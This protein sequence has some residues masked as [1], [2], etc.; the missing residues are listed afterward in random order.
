MLG[1]LACEPPAKITSP[2]PAASATVIENKAQ[3]I[4]STSTAMAPESVPAQ[5]LASASASAPAYPPC[6]PEVPEP[7]NEMAWV[8]G[9]RILLREKIYFDFE[10]SRLKPQSFP[11]LDAVGDILLRNPALRVEVE[12][13]LGDPQQHAYGR[14]LSQDRAESVRNYLVA[15]KGVPASQLSY[16]GYENAKPISDTRTEEGRQKNRRIELVILGWNGRIQ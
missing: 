9:C 4:A 6:P 3:P 2:T 13:H 5:P 1:T 7:A 11:V 14:K 8:S 12:G 15:Q 16:K 10:K